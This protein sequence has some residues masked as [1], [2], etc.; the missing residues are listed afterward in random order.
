MAKPFDWNKD[1]N[2]LLQRE[3]EVSFEDVVTAVEEGNLLDDAPHYNQDLHPH[4]RMMTVLIR[5]YCYLVPYVE[6]K[7]KIFLK[8]I[9]PS[10]D[11]T[12]KYLI[13]E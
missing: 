5:D 9:I 11:A 8:T 13:H 4:Q 7:D 1:K 10:R 3:R 12:K 6:D 2:V